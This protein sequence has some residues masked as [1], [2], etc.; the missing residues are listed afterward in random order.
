MDTIIT[1]GKY[2]GLTYNHVIEVE[3]LYLSNKIMTDYTVEE[4]YLSNKKMWIT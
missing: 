2:K 1:F 3:E 4:L